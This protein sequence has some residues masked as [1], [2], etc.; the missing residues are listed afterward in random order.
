MGNVQNG[1]GH[2]SGGPTPNKLPAAGAAEAGRERG[3]LEGLMAIDGQLVALVGKRLAE[4]TRW[5]AEA[6]Q[7]QSPP[8]PALWE[9]F[10]WLE[11]LTRTEP[12]PGLAAEELARA[13]KTVAAVTDYAL[14]PP[15]R[16]AYLGPKYSF[17]YLASVKY[18]TEAALLSPVGSIATVFE[19]IVHGQAEFG[20]V[21]IEN[22]TDGRIVDTLSMF[23][24]HRV[25]IC[26]EVLLPIH[27]CLLGRCSLE[28]VEEVHSKPQALSQC[29]H[30]ISQHLPQAKLCEI[31]STTAAAKLAAERPHVAAIAAKEA[32]R[33]YG[34]RVISEN[35][36][37]NRDNLTRFAVLGDRPTRPS[38]NDKTS[39]MFQIPHR[40]GALAEAMQVFRHDEL[41]MTWIESFPIPGNTS[42]YLFFIEFEGHQSDPVVVSALEKLGRQTLRFDVLGSYA[43][44]KS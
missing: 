16:V 33:H 18:F 24:R 31:G 13:L 21:P 25:R 32:G 9:Q 30:W 34:L 28:E 20:V 44:G 11:A 1:P 14:K 17:S 29:R 39:I 36:E 19:D 12:L 7:G 2:P 4:L 10:A 41:N 15:T 22:S 23:A 42:E 37:D 27:H 5:N 26:G 3:R 6:A 43:K 38:G 35:I 8:P 40:S